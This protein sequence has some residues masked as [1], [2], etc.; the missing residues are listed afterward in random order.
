M[1][2]CYKCG[3]TKPLEE[4][5][6]ANRETDKRQKVCK[7]CNKKYRRDNKEKANQ[8]NTDYYIA[9]KE[10]ISLENKK[11]VRSAKIDII[12]FLG[13]RCKKCGMLYDGK[14]GAA[15][16]CHH[17]DPSKKKFNIGWCGGKSLE[18]IL[19]EVKK[20]ELLCRNCHNILHNGEY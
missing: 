1:K 16:D 4:F 9:H 13:G 17:K 14:N 18:S 11:Q 10:E 7:Q 3:E 5:A 2:R 19:E 12:N 20:C 8:Y 15:F 6:F